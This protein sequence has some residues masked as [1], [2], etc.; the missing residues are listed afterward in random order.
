MSDASS[1]G[2]PQSFERPPD[3]RRDSWKE[4]AAH[5]KRDV[6]TVQ[7]WEKRN[8]LPVHRHLHERRSAVYGY[9]AELD[10]WW[11][12]G[13]ATQAESESAQRAFFFSKRFVMLSAG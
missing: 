8:G 2:S 10:A 11:N 13:R 5:L 3:D 4:I 7:R 1:L 12:H 9:R 6:T